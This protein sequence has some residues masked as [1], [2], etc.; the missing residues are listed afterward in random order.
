MRTTANSQDRKAED[1]FSSSDTG[2]YIPFYVV[3]NKPVPDH[4]KQGRIF[5]WEHLFIPSSFPCTFSEYL[6]INGMR[7]ENMSHWGLIQYGD[8]CSSTEN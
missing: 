8:S 4:Q 3:G 7:M 6:L 2:K 1:R 5:P